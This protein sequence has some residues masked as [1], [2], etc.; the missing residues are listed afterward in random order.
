MASLRWSPPLRD[1]LTLPWRLA[2]AGARVTLA[3][4]ALAAPEGPIRRP[5]GYADLVTR[6][7]GDGGYA[8]QVTSF[9]TDEDGPMRLVAQLEALLAPDRPVGRL[10]E[11]NG[12]LDRLLAEDGPLLPLLVPGGPVDRLMAPGGP[13][14]RLMVPGG[15]L[16]RLLAPRGPLEQVVADAGLLERLL[17]TGGALDALTAEGGGIE[18]LLVDDACSSACWPT[19]RWSTAC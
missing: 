1:A 14:E 10:I 5:G 2:G 8:E 19:A 11:R 6:L 18:R 15:P 13:A 16:G 4:G 7:I 3:L 9:L 12:S 17:R